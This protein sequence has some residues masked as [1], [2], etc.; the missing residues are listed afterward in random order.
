MKTDERQL[1]V[2]ILGGHAEEYSY[3]LDRYASQVFSLVTRLVKNRLDAEEITQDS[4]VRAFTALDSFNFRSEFSTWI[5]RI[6]Y[7]CAIQHLRKQKHEF[8]VD[9]SEEQLTCISD[10][11]ADEVLSVDSS[12]R[13][14][15]LQRAIDMLPPNDRALI[16]L[17]YHDNRSISDIAYILS[18]KESNVAVRL[19][20][21]R[22]HLYV[23][24]KQFE[25]ENK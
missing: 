5:C 9:I 4:F 1:I 14:Q 25:N 21:I 3:F 16:T 12:D 8:T 19:Y 20:R 22:K 10:N 7:N 13:I 11:M 24:I 2:R 18:L 23:L 6:A 15:I 17:F